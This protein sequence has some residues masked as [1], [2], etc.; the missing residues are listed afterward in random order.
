MTSHD[1]ETP[2]ETTDG[3][4]KGSG[5]SRRDFMKAV[6]GAGFAAVVLRYGLSGGYAWAAGPGPGTGTVPTGVSTLG[7]PSYVPE[8]VHLTW[9]ADPSTQV[10]VSWASASQ[11]SGPT[12][13]LTPAAG[14]QTLAERSYTDGLSGETVYCYHVTI[15]GLTPNTTYSY[16]VSDSDAGETAATF[17]SSF[18]TASQGRFAFAFTSFGDLATPGAGAAYVLADGSTIYSTTYSESQWNA[19]NAV[20]EVEALANTTGLMPPLFHLLNGDLCYGDKETIN[21]SGQTLT[22]TTESS[23]LRRSGVTSPSTC[24]GLQLTGPGCP[25]SVTMRSSS[26]TVPTGSTPTT[27]G[28]CSPQ[29]AATP[30]QGSYYS[31]QVG[32]V[33]FI[34]LDANDVCYQGSGA[35][36]VAGVTT[37]D[38]AATLSG[39]LATSTTSTTPARSLPIRTAPFLPVGPPPTPRRCG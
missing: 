13:T 36:N 21:S 34:S 3:H 37:T 23:P 7:A 18:T 15:S 4:L 25:A 16:T 12:V 17:T 10:T 24:R 26:T 35:Y 28:L 14:T 31:F 2:P 9:G 11:E 20:S 6:S 33:L 5:L 8:Q 19:Y 29:T 27:P 1:D 39:R 32:S 30:F 22:G 38:A